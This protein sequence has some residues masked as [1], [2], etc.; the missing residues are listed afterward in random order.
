MMP[1][2]SLRRQ[3][4]RTM[5]RTPPLGLVSGRHKQLL[6]CFLIAG[7]VRPVDHIV[8][9]CSMACGPDGALCMAR[10]C[11]LR[12]PSAPGCAATLSLATRVQTC[13][14]VMTGGAGPCFEMACRICSSSWVCCA[15]ASG[16]D[17][18]SSRMALVVLGDGAGGVTGLSSLAAARRQPP[19][20]LAQINSKRL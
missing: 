2:A 7:G 5:G 1:V 15:A 3:L 10:M 6:T 12:V 17:S 9:H 19:R 11:E 13:L 14:E 20:I 18:K 8:A 4:K 16:V